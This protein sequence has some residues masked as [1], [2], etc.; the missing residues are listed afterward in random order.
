M[1]DGI[2][3]GAN[4]HGTT[5]TSPLC[6]SSLNSMDSIHS[7]FFF[8]IVVIQILCQVHLMY[9]MHFH[10]FFHPSESFF[11]VLK[12]VGHFFS[13]LF[14]CF[15]DNKSMHICHFCHFDCWLRL[16]TWQRNRFKS[17]VFFALFNPLFDAVFIVEQLHQMA[18]E[19]VAIM[20]SWDIQN[21]WEFNFSTKKKWNN[22]WMTKTH[23]QNENDIECSALVGCDWKEKVLLHCT[24]QFKYNNPT[25]FNSNHFHSLHPPTIAQPH[26]YR[27]PSILKHTIYSTRYALPIFQTCFPFS[28]RCCFFCEW[29]RSCEFGEILVWAWADGL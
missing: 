23:S 4:E 11:V 19:L 3:V 6:M 10:M 16:I 22:E 18:F 29:N 14:V 24:G 5:V 17:L 8:E 13:F 15:V 27:V 9:L 2:D 20:R 26:I 1:Y 7:I 12:F 25:Q 21:L 28:S